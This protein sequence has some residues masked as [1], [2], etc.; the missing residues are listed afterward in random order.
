M[1]ALIVAN[2]AD[3]FGAVDA[4]QRVFYAT[5]DWVAGAE[6]LGLDRE[7]LRTEELKRA[8]R[9]DRVVVVTEGLADR[10]RELGHEPVLIPN[11]CDVERFRMTDDASL[12]GDIDLPSPRAGVFGHLS[13]RIDL[14][15]LEAVAAAGTSLLLVGTLQSSFSLDPLL[16]FENVR[17]L[18]PRPFEL[19]PGYLRAIDV[20]LT[21]YRS[22]DA[23]N[24]ASF[25]LKTLEYLAAG[26]G[27]VSTDLPAVRWLD[28]DLIAV[29]DGPEAFSAAVDRALSVPL[30]PGIIDERRTFAERHGW[31]VRVDEFAR[32]LGLGESGSVTEREV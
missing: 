14:S 28:T 10:W 29:A 17:Y 19:M 25:P 13:R 7:Y 18:G 22:S 27:A 20:G 31:A 16:K 21:P 6:L 1:Y 23:F 26:R 12:P 2:Q 8:E 30:T 11:G 3:L 24:R 9:V 15:L 4:Q 32:V 5:D